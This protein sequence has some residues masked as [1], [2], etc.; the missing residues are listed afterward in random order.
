MENVIR[1][2][3]NALS[4]AAIL[5]AVTAP[6]AH[7]QVTET[8]LYSFLGGCD[9]STPYASVVADAKGALY[10]T[11]GYGGTSQN[12]S[13]NRGTVFKLTPPAPG[14]TAWTETVLW[15]FSGG[16]DGC[17]PYA[18]LFARNEN[19]SGK[20]TLYGT[21]TGQGAATAPSLR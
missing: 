19:P 8:V 7:A 16:S 5:W 18:E 3:L 13:G 20:K 12:C 17:Y 15:N 4:A 1:L 10:G 9:A 2:A 14:K 21:T 11:T 6:P